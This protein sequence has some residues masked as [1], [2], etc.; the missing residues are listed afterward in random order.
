ME[1][2]LI[3]DGYNIISSW[4]NLKHIK[5]ENLEHAREKLIEAL[6]THRSLSGRS[7]SVV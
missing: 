6:A 1:E 4:P 2:Y 7:E 3:V 5:E